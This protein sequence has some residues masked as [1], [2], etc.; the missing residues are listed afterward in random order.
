MKALL[1]KIFKAFYINHDAITAC[2]KALPYDIGHDDF[3]DSPKYCDY[4][5]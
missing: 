4:Y 2:M 5:C 1:R 3:Y